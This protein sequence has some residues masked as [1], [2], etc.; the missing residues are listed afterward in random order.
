MKRIFSILAL[1]LALA[2]VLQTTA[3]PAAARKDKFARKLNTFNSIVKELQTNYV[4]TLDADKIMNGTIE[5]LLY[6]IDPYTEYYPSDNQ[7]E[8]RSISEG[9]Y[10]GIGSVILKRGDNVIIHKPSEGS[11]SRK[12]GLRP[13]DIILAI[14]GDTITPTMQVGDVS[15]KLRGQAGTEVRIDLKRPYAADSL[16]SVTI[17]RDNIKVNP[18]SYAGVDDD[19]IA[20]IGLTTFNEASARRVRDALSQFIKEEPGLKGLVLDLRDNGGGLLEGAVAVASNFVPKGTEILR[21]RGRDASKEKIYKTTSKPLALDLPLAVLINEGSASSSEIVTGSMQDLDR[22]VIVGE[23]SFGKG[24]VQSTRPLPG[25]DILKITTGRYYIPSGRL[26]QAIDYSHRDD[27][28]RPVRVPDSLTTV[29]HTKAGRE[30]RDGGG[31][32]PDVKVELPEMNRML[33]NIQADLWA[34]DFANKY[35]ATHKEMPDL[36]DSTVMNKV[37]EEFK[38][39]IDPDKFKY[40]RQCEN[41]L[42]YLR[43]SAEAEGY[44][45]DSVKAQFEVMSGLLKHNLNHDLDFNAAEIKRILGAEIAMRYLSDAE[46]TKRVLPDDEVYLKAKEIL[47]DPARTRKILRP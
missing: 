6:Q 26:I 30:V 4:D 32:T 18:I 41:A 10:A 42:D 19:G 20:Y 38:A 2:A 39:F 35:A 47:L 37:F 17:V 27:S 15:K 23:R 5:A 8:L 36:A 16:F 21:T 43:K 14:D 28:G 33:Y 46:Q 40:D 34:F 3:A 24:L 9:Q 25:D 44:M 29:F 11:P 1:V 31:I 12:A 7:D 13:G 45:N 22:A